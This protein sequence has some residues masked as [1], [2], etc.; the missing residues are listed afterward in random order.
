MAESLIAQGMMSSRPC[1][2]A[3]LRSDKAKVRAGG[4]FLQPQRLVEIFRQIR[5][6]KRDDGRRGVFTLA[7]RTPQCFTPWNR[8]VG[9]WAESRAH[10]ST[11]RTRQA[12]IV[13]GDNTPYHLPGLKRIITGEII[14]TAATLFRWA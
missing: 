7:S 2:S 4:R 6:Q 14:A 5:V 11:G 9:V 13:G 1:S 10:Y 12:A 3:P 8:T